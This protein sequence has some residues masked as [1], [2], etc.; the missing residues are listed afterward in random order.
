[1]SVLYIFL[2]YKFRDHLRIL[3]I[4]FYEWNSTNEILR[5]KF[6]E[7]NSTNEILRMKFYEWNSQNQGW[8]VGETEFI[9]EFTILIFSKSTNLL[10]C[11]HFRNSEIITRNFV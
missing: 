2:I 10:L 5:M 9:S 6:Y 7:W 1:M 11:I 3:W 8:N 4:K